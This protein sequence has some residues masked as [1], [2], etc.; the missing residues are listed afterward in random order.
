MYKNRFMSMFSYIILAFLVKSKQWIIKG[1]GAVVAIYMAYHQ[2]YFGFYSL[3]VG[4]KWVK[5]FWIINLATSIFHK[6]N[7]IGTT[8]PAV[9]RRNKFFDSRWI[10]R[11]AI[12]CKRHF[13]ILIRLSLVMKLIPLNVN[14][15]S[16]PKRCW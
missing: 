10:R 5:P 1:V 13:L 7:G 8:A 4:V 3:G 15:F 11:F 6:E 16:V 12:M 2:C 9:F 14:N